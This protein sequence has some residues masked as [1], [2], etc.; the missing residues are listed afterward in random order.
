MILF[1]FLLNAIAP[2]DSNYY[3]Y[4]DRMLSFY[5][6]RWE[7][8]YDSSRSG[9]RT[10]QGC[11]DLQNWFVTMEAKTEAWLCNWL[12]IRY[13][14]CL[15]GD[16]LRQKN[17]HRFEPRFKIKGKLSLL[18]MVIPYYKKGDNE[19]GLGIFRGDNNL[20]SI[21]AFF[22]LK[23]IDRNNSLKFVPD[24]PEKIVYKAFPAYV[25][26]RLARRWESGYFKAY[27]EKSNTSWLVSRYGPGRSC[28][29]QEKESFGNLNLRFL[30]TY[31]RFDFGTILNFYENN[32]ACLNKELRP[33]WIGDTLREIEFQPSIGFNLSQKWRPVFYYYF[34]YKSAEDTILYKRA[35]NGQYLD[36][37]FRPSQRTLWRFGLQREW[38]DIIRDEL[39]INHRLVIG[40]EYTFPSGSFVIYE[41]IEADPAQMKITRMHNHT[42]VGLLL[43]I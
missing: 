41:G 7:I 12:G 36:F 20:N 29:F 27:F 25:T 19:F 35:G 34:N 22:V 42:Y 15:L 39:R 11:H 5:P 14:Y 8:G 3:Y 43:K 24:G 4:M 23:A 17:Y 32:R 16:Y 1:L 33:G 10:I 28:W 37:E 21:E 38:I 13:R 26:L 18:L 30:N 6:D 2:E 9:L 31:G 40:F